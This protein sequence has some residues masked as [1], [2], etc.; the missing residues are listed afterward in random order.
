MRISDWSS[1]VCSSDLLELNRLCKDALRTY[2]NVSALAEPAQEEEESKDEMT[3]P[4]DASKSAKA[5]E[6]VFASR[7]TH[8]CGRIED[9]KSVVEGQSVSVRVDLGS[10]RIL[11]KKTHY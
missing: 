1:D 6:N 5:Q 3:R 10:D 11:K 9:R 7:I 8:F 4:A 2:L